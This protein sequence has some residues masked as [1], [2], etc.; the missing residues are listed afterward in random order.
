MCPVPQFYLIVLN[1]VDRDLW[2]FQRPFQPYILVLVPDHVVVV[3]VVIITDP[4]IH[5]HSHKQSRVLQC[6]PSRRWDS[7]YWSSRGLHWVRRGNLMRRC[8]W[9]NGWCLA[10]GCGDSCCRCFCDG[11]TVSGVPPREYHPWCCVGL[12]GGWRIPERDSV[13][14]S[15]IERDEMQWNETERSG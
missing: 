14:S 9:H 10:C 12:V 13:S 8:V 15:C 4:F 11:D 7:M 3:V 1:G 5:G 2:T 6:C